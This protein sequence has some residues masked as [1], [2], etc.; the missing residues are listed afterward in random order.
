M[1]SQ[2]DQFGVVPEGSIGP[3]DLADIGTRLLLKDVYIQRMRQRV[4]DL[5]AEIATL[6]EQQRSVT[7]DADA[8][9]VAEVADEIATSRS[10]GKARSEERVT[11]V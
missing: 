11:K 4:L 2:T 3:A 7:E 8:R 9:R 5:T 10:N 1:E 6:H